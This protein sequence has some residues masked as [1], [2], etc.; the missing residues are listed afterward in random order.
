MTMDL[1]NLIIHARML[2]LY[3]TDWWTYHLDL[4]RCQNFWELR[5]LMH[6]H[7]VPKTFQS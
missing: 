2:Q 6:L 5:K 3:G 4:S 1:R 7:S